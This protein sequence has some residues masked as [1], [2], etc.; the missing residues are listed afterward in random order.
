MTK[1]LTPINL[2]GNELQNARIQNLGGAPGSPVLGQV[3]FDTAL[4]QFGVWCGSGPGWV[5]LTAGSSANVSQS[6]NSAAA[7]ILKVSAGANTNIADYAGG[8]GLLK[9]SASGVVS[10]A[11]AG[12]DYLSPTGS[13][14]AL[15]GLTQPQISGLTAA[16]AALA[17]LAGPAFTGLPTTPTP[18]GSTGIAN[19]GYVDSVAQGL[20]AKP[21]AKAIATSSITLSA[22]Q[23]IDGVSVVAGDRVLAQAQSTASQNGLWVVAA[24]AWTRPT[25]FATGSSQQGVYVFVEGGTANASTGWIL[26]GTGA[27]TV[28]T[29]S[30]TWTQFTGAGDI[31]VGAGLA[32]TGNQI[33]ITSGGLPVAQG[34][35]GATTAGGAKT[36]LGFAGIFNS[37]AIGDGTSTTLT[38]THNLGNAVPHVQ[39]WDVSGGNPVAVIC[40][41]TATST[42]AVQLSFTVAPASSSIKCVVV[43]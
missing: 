26:T 10:P 36:N 3:Y 14:A 27:I 24:G 18:T 22:P 4:G 39:V 2:S 6:G 20:D 13:G 25:D 1:I 35:T 34:G 40:D 28:D 21:S 12:T 29:S 11:V 41:I 5:Y 37:A 30:Q 33:S 7:G 19:K 15:T 9:S 23:T 16:L 8:T 17:P 42:N 38:V 43:G 32:K 31:T